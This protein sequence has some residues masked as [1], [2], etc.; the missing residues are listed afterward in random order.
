MRPNPY[1]QPPGAKT[2]APLDVSAV[3]F[4]AFAPQDRTS[5]RL[6]VGKFVVSK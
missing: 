2:G 1:F 3:T 6:E 4:I 5:G